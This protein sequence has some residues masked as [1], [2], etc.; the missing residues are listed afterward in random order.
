MQAF[1]TVLASLAAL[2]AGILA[3]IFILPE[4]KRSKLNPFGKFLH[5]F[6]NFKEF[7]L[8][9][10]LKFMYIVA[11]AYSVVYGALLT[12]SFRTD[13]IFVPGEFDAETGEYIEGYYETV[14]EWDGWQGLLMMILGPIAIRIA[15]ELIL[16]GIGALKSLS[17]INTKLG[18]PLTIKVAEEEPV[19]QTAPAVE[20]ITVEET[21]VEAPVVE[22]PAAD[23]KP[24]FCIH[25]GQRLDANGN[26]LNPVCPKN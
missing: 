20:E 10:I 23:P 22:A 7:W 21:A 13:E 17:D 11:T 8:T 25:C 14:L 5:D 19:D 6:L 26:C 15:Y 12:F 16:L 1:I 3:F 4:D 2:A 18:K 9:L 24:I